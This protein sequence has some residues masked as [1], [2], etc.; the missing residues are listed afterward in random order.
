MESSLFT[1][2]FVRACLLG[3]IDN[4][5]PFHAL[6]DNYRLMELLFKKHVLPEGEAISISLHTAAKNGYAHGL[7]L[8]LNLTMT[9]VD[10]KDNSVSACCECRC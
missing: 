7:C 1:L 2:P 8:V 3:T 4:G 10:S 5:S 6:K 9:S